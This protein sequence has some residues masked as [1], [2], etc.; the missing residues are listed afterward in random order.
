MQFKK[1]VIAIAFIAATQL[2]HA[3]NSAVEYNDRII[4]HQNSIS[5]A[6]TEFTDAFANDSTLTQL[7]AEAY[8]QIIAY[9]TQM[10]MNDVSVMGAYQ[11]DSTF[12]DAATNLFGFYLKSVQE[13][14]LEIVRIIYNENATLEDYTRMNEIIDEIT[15]EESYYDAAFTKAQSAFAEKFGFTLINK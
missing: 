13:E 2:L 1:G 9:T 4:N 11:G 12:R 8:L 14:Y 10:A 3:Q 6:I 5:V 7:R 15:L